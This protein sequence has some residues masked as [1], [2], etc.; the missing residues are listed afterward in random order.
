[1]RTPEIAV[2]FRAAHDVLKT[3][4]GG[5]PTRGGI[6]Y[7]T[8][9]LTTKGVSAIISFTGALTG[10]MIL[11]M[12]E[13]TALQ[14]V[15]RMMGQDFSDMDALARSGI[16]EMANVIAGSAGVLLAQIGTTIDIAPP[17]ILLGAGG[18]LTSLD[19]PRPRVEVMTECG[20]IEVQISAKKAR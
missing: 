18:S 6:S 2:F 12:S 15:S 3:E 13:E 16:G 1:M 5:P 14:L 17:L 11:I 10:M 8:D 9:D 20:T 4:L 7:M 19:V